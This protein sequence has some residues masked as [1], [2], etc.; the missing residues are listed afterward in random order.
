MMCT[1]GRYVLKL[2]A[3]KGQ[4]CKGPTRV[5]NESSQIVPDGMGAGIHPFAE[6]TAAREKSNT[7]ISADGTPLQ[8]NAARWPWMYL[9]S[10]VQG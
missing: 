9:R 7:S 8:A 10:S 5:D 6:S 2:S 1:Y 4:S 3:K